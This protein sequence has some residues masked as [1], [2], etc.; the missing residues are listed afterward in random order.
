VIHKLIDLIERN[1]DARLRKIE[2]TSEKN[3]N[4]LSLVTI[5]AEKATQKL[6]NIQI[7]EERES[8]QESRRN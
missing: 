7:L 5:A 1:L 8:R 3:A 6:R 4:L 2:K